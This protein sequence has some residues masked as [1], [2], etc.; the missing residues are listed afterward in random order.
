[1]GCLIAWQAPVPRAP[2]LSDIISQ[3]RARAVV[4][5]H[6]PLPHASGCAVPPCPRPPPRLGPYARSRGPP[7]PPAGLCPTR[8]PQPLWRLRESRTQGGGRVSFR[9]DSIDIRIAR[10]SSASASS[11]RRERRRGQQP[12]RG[13]W[14]RASR[15]PHRPAAHDQ[16]RRGPAA[17]AAGRAHKSLGGRALE[18]GGA[19]AS[20]G[21]LQGGN[22]PT[23]ERGACAEGARW[24]R[25][26][27]GGAGG[28]GGG[29]WDRRIA[30]PAPAA[31]RACRAR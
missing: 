4:V 31:G 15:R 16:R 25:E 19:H 6:C 13:R 12:G 11:N 1:M 2:P 5:P 29:G 26:R 14:P 8:L 20:Q 10:S 9:P 23:A 24:P 30:P 3:G 28:E 22:E 18:R 21:A 7:A 27:A 17:A